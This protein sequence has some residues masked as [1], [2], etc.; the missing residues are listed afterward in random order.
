M[1]RRKIGD[2][3]EKYNI[4]QLL[5]EINENK[6]E[7]R[8]IV[9]DMAQ[10][11]R[12]Y[13]ASLVSLKDEYNAIIKKNSAIGNNVVSVNLVDLLEEICWL[14]E[15][16]VE[17]IDISMILNVSLNG[18]HDIDDFFGYLM[19]PDGCSVNF[20]LSGNN[21]Q[22]YY[23]NYVTSLVMDFNSVQNDNRTLLEHCSVV[24]KKRLNANKYTELVIDR[25]VESINVDFTLNHLS[26]DTSATWC[27]ADLF[28]QA[29]LNC[30][31]RKNNTRADKVRQKVK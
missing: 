6:R 28:T 24:T 22:G 18:E 8:A 16:N 9:Q 17:D 27:Y 19:I 23:F 3:M 30:E 10:I 20:R 31:E 13:E 25:D 4:F 15:C 2:K 21:K 7:M 5:E 29:V 26:L 11:R 14:S 1:I 12:D